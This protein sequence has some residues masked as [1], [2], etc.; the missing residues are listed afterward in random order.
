VDIGS[1]TTG[2][3]D[4]LLNEAGGNITQISVA[5][6]ANVDKLLLL[7]QQLD[8]NALPR[9][10]KIA[11]S[12]SQAVTEKNKSKLEGLLPKLIEITEIAA[13]KWLVNNLIN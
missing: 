13:F 12:I 6:Q 4:A 9:V 11:D 2:G 5:A 3:G 8:P 7:V 10:E 1:I